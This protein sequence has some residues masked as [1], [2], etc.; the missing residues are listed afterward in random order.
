MLGLC[1]GSAGALDLGRVYVC[2]RL[3]LLG[4]LGKCG[5]L[6]LYWASIC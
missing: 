6:L 3:H 1:R 5:N 4:A 2:H